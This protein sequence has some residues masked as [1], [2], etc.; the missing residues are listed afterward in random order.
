MQEAVAPLLEHGEQV[1]A[2]MLTL[3]G[4][5]PW[6]T[7]SWGVLSLPFLVSYYLT[8]TDRRVIV[9]RLNAGNNAIESLVFIE[10]IANVKISAV[11]RRP[12]WSSFRYESPSTGKP[13]RINVHRRK[14]DLMDT[15]VGQLTA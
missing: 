5:S 7:K 11:R 3:R 15:V 13:I 12:L 2:A 14:R 1:V 4:P 8:V 9:H 6:L 10:P